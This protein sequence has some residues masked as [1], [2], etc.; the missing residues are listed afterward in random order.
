MHYK[1]TIIIMLFVVLTNGSLF[2]QNDTLYYFDFE[3]V[4][5]H[6]QASGKFDFTYNNGGTF[7]DAEPYLPSG[8]T[9]IRPHSNK[10]HSVDYGVF[11][12]GS[13]FL[14]HSPSWYMNQKF[15]GV[16]FNHIE[17]ELDSTLE[18]GQFYKLTF[19]IG[20]FKSHNFQP[21]HYGVRFSEDKIMKTKPGGLLAD[22]DIFFAFTK[23]LE[24]EEVQ[25]IYFA[26]Q[27]V[28]YIY[29]GLFEEDS[30]RIPK[31]YIR[32]NPGKISY[33]DT[34]A[35][36]FFSKPT[37][38]MLDN[39]LIEK[40][41]KDR[42]EF[43]DVFFDTDKDELQNSEDLASIK[44]MAS[45]LINHPDYFILIQGYTDKTGTLSYNLNLSERRASRIKDMLINNGASENQIVTLGKGIHDSKS[46]RKENILDRK[47]SFMIFK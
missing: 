26:K 24:L 43:K 39:I 30:A 21:A 15:E 40:M 46:G 45:Y 11:D 7:K 35:H 38:V 34:A 22:P 31:P 47:V 29:F 20:N 44:E 27:P 41:D 28:N 32:I 19:L 42:I 23:Q 17:L 5:I 12:G 8:R 1:I 3:N 2:G 18:S 33:S 6:Y 13:G 10:R 4:D 16:S 36:V 9:V 14:Y 37:R 25:A